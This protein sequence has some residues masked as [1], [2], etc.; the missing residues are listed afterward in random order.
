MEF[1]ATFIVAF[2]SFIVFV[3]IMNQ[4]L[5]KPIQDIVEKR[6][7]LID[8]NYNEANQNQEKSKSILQDRL[9]KL[10]SA[11]SR[12]K[13][14]TSQTLNKIKDEKHKAEKE[15][16]DKV[17]SEIE[18][19]I[20]ALNNTQQEAI[21]TLSKDVINLAQMISDKFIETPLRLENVDNQTIEKIMQD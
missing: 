12:V 13:E 15:A 4:I 14:E 6:K 17:N 3:L 1:N 7:N 19:N 2:F 10:S 11:R 5:Y 20:N 21:N 9:D 8:G 18:E 16:K